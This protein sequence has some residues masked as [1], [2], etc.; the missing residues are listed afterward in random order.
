MQVEWH[1]ID[2][3]G[4]EPKVQMTPKAYDH[5]EQEI[6]G[7]LVATGETGVV[8]LFDRESPDPVPRT[9]ALHQKTI[10]ALWNYSEWTQN[11]CETGFD[12][13]LHSYRRVSEFLCQAG[14]SY[15]SL[16]EHLPRFEQQRAEWHL[17]QLSKIQ[18]WM[19]KFKGEV[20]RE[21]LCLEN[22]MSESQKGQEQALTICFHYP[23]KNQTDA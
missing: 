9:L 5:Y 19:E 12:E 21:V 3:S 16:E 14:Q 13:N 7:A 23:P 17:E 22:R 18:Q 11:Q 8:A 6:V 20:I 4:E 2:P 10:G 15:E 1:T